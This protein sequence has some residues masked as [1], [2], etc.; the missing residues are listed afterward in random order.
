MPKEEI[1]WKHKKATELYHKEISKK[2]S[3][4]IDEKYVKDYIISKENIKVV[5]LGIGDG[6]E[7]SWLNRLHNVKE[8]IGVD[9]SQEMLDICRIVAKK[10]RTRINLIKDNLLSLKIFKEL[11]E[12]EDL[13]LIYL[14]LLNTLG[15]FTVKQREK[16]LKNVRNLMK[17]N[18]RLIMCL[19]KKP[20]DIKAKIFLPLQV[21]TKKNLGNRIKI[22]TLIE[23]G[24][25]ET[26]WLPIL[27]KY[28]RLPRIWY[29][30][31][32]NNV[33]FYVGKE[34]IIISHR[35][36]KEEIREIAKKT[37]L[38]IENLIEGKFMWVVILKV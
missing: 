20:E 15:N 5:S 22:G 27:E 34:K 4:V 2:A 1:I 11:V 23:Y 18:D 6:R 10:Y 12:K 30:D 16:I 13:S 29:D 28:H 32:T 24:S 37:K 17:K 36:S 33:T 35:F 25:L 26:L 19:Y 3:G 31:K 8:I 7:L 14:C 21:K 38:K 9:Y